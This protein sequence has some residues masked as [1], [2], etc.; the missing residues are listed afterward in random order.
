M[1]PAGWDELQIRL[2]QVDSGDTPNIWGMNGRHELFFLEESNQLVPVEG[3]MQHVTC[4]QGGGYGNMHHVTCGE[5]G[6][7]AVWAMWRR[8]F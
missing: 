5:A 4:G 6:V 3:S 2:T 8:F 7:W 1:L